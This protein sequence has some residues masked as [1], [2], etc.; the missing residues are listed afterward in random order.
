MTFVSA[1]VRIHSHK[2][3]NKRIIKDAEKNG[4]IG[5]EETVGNDEPIRCL[6]FLDYY[7]IGA[8]NSSRG[9]NRLALRTPTTLFS[10]DNR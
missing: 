4:R 1:S 7:L 6:V 2:N 5:T 8:A 3:M 9:A 10:F